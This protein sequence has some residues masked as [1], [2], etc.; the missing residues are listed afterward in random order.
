[1]I[2]NLNDDGSAPRGRGRRRKKWYTIE[3][4]VQS[5]FIEVARKFQLDPDHLAKVLCE[6]FALR[7]PKTL[8][9]ISKIVVDD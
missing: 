4:E 2:N 9:I 5:R 1:M 3:I 7:P 6:D 8:T